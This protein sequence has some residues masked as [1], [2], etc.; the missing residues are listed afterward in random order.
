MKRL[1]ALGAAV[2]LALGVSATALAA[3]SIVGSIDMPQ[4]SSSQG[5][6]TLK[7]VV[8]EQYEGEVRDVITSIDA[9]S[10]GSTLS[11]VLSGLSLADIKIPIIKMDSVIEIEKADLSEFKFL[12]PVMELSISDAEPT[13]KNP[14]EVTFVANNMTDNIEIF[15]LHYCDIHEWE[16]LKTEKVSDNQ[17][18]AAFHSASPVVLVYKEKAGAAGVDNAKSPKT[19]DVGMGWLVLVMDGMT[20]V[21]LM[22]VR[23][24]KRVE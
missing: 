16:L 17:I 11:D 19:G 8:P 6:V 2:V 21:G 18:K 1:A 13:E 12:S 22:A 10:T 7:A 20:G 9:A 4:V 3:P 24:A 15:V 23:K 5:S 14:V